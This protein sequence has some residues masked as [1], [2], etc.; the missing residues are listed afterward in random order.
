[1]CAEAVQSRL[2][3]RLSRN[4]LA[5]SEHGIHQMAMVRV[6]VKNGGVVCASDVR[7]SHKEKL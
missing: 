6:Y 1:M 3:A 2:S 5:W 4:P 7:V